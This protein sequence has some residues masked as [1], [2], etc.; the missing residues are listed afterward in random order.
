MKKLFN[1]FLVIFSVFP[2]IIFPFFPEAI[3][4]S[5]ENS[6]SVC[7]K[8]LIPSLFPFLF[9]SH[10][11]SLFSGD[12]LSDI[13]SP[14]LMPVFK[15]SK[16]AC[17]TVILG[18]LGGFP[19]GATDAA[20]L[21]SEKKISKEEAE[22]LPLFC[23]NAGL[24]FTVG[25]LGVSHFHSVKI[26]FVLYF[27]H[28]FS[29]FVIAL[30]TRPEKPFPL[31]Y[32]KRTS[33]PEPES[34]PKAFGKAVEGS[35]KSLSLISGNFIIFKLFSDI[36]CLCFKKSILLSFISGLFEV[37]GGV[38][39]MPVTKE[40]LI[41]TSFLLSFNGICVHIQSMCF[42][43]PRGLSFKKLFFGKIL[44]GILSAFLMYISLPEDFLVSKALPPMSFYILVAA[45]PLL[46]FIPSKK[47]KA[48]F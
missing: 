33:L 30:F 35:V 42:L 37:T 45:L 16:N 4:L 6:L 44:T 23:N 9:F 17:R 1:Y 28:L 36:L 12:F 11:A 26:G 25:A 34:F 2:L 18:V 43:A 29:S 38:L 19:T 39:S 46:L 41:L 47:K 3:S 27:Y 20:L 7:I 32:G 13:L 14:V 8:T 5:V 10:L 31:S 22:R 21:Y 24:M 40:G 15:I 48:V